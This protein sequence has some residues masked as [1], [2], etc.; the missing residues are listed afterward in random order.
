MSLKTGWRA[1]IRGRRV[2]ADL[3]QTV[4]KVGKWQESAMQSA[5]DWLSNGYLRI[6]AAGNRAET[7]QI[8]NWQG[9][10]AVLMMRTVAD[11]GRGRAR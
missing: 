1:P 10:R 11:L 9:H 5:C 3:F 2:A 8:P 7:G 4:R 6:A